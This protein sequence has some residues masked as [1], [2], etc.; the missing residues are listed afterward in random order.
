MIPYC[1]WYIFLNSP[2]CFFMSVLVFSRCVRN[3]KVG[4]DKPLSRHSFCAPG[5]QA[6]LSW[7]LC[8]GSARAAA[9][10][11]TGLCPHLE[12]RSGK[13]C[14]QTHP[15]HWQ[16]SFSVVVWLRVLS[17]VLLLAGAAFRFCRPP[18]DVSTW[19]SPWAGHTV[20]LCFFKAS[21]ASLPCPLRRSLM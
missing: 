15:V 10:V 18:R 4:N 19:L 21:R 16:N 2:F 1:S 14:V 11:G 7:V 9:T 12:A 17:S 13:N 8:S 6:R 5:A 20:A 3:S